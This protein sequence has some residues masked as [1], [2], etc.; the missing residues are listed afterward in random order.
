[1]LRSL[2]NVVF[3]IKSLIRMQFDDSYVQ[4]MRKMVPFSVIE[5]PRGEAWVEIHGMK[6]SPIE[7]TSTLFSRL[8]CCSDGSIS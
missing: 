6:F 5:G 3:N 8:R 4:E 2:S 1:M 7:I